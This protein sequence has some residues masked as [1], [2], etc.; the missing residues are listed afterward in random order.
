MHYE[1]VKKQM[2]AFDCTQVVH[3]VFSRLTTTGSLRQGAG[4]AALRL[5]QID[6]LVVDEVDACL[7]EE[8][9]SA[10]LQR[11][12]GGQLAVDPLQQQQP[13][14]AGAS[15]KPTLARRQTLF[16]S[17]T[18]PQRQHFRRQCV[19]QRWCREAPLLVHAEPEEAVPAQLRH[20]WA[21]CTPAKRVAALR[22]LLRRHEPTLSGAIVFVRP[23]LPLRKIAEALGGI[24][25]EGA[26]AVLSTE[27]PLPV[28]AAAVRGLRE[29]SSRLLVSTPLGARGLDIPHCSHVYLVGL[30]ESAA[31]YLHAAGRCG[32]MGRPG[33]V[34]V[35]AGEKE[36]FALG[37][38]ANEL[39]IEF[40]DARDGDGEEDEE[41][42]EAEADGGGA[43]GEGSALEAAASDSNS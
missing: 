34:T 32:R 33:L 35:L 21:P 1:R 25:D 37:R 12:L 2:A 14:P 38:L 6:M 11:M 30:P 23:T 13:S 41:P 18:L 15:R 26:P 8:Q 22:V 5:P 7:A 40:H 36:E 24:V 39:R 17:A 19:D 43:A 20:G 16:V 28:R 3:H 9:T 31:A 10:L 4:G 29:R 42:E 27:Q